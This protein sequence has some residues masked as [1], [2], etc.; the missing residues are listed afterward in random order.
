MTK[1]RKRVLVVEDDTW[2]L[3]QFKRQ[4]VVA[5]YEVSG[6]TDGIAAMDA[7]DSARPDVI[8]LDMFLTGPNGM[9]LLHEL[10]SHSDLAHIPV[11]V[12]TTSAADIPKDSLNAY[13]ARVVLDKTSMKP[14]DIV[15]AVEKVVP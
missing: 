5:G 11:V 14:A 2:F 10:A 12:C 3:E 9:V 13:G 1:P 6:A 7:I 4:L 15:A 8:V